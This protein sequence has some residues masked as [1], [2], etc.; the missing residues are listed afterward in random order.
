[1]PSNA[2]TTQ[3]RVVEEVCDA[4]GVARVP[5]GRIPRGLLTA[6]GAVSPLVREFREVRHQ[7]ERPWLVDDTAARTAFGLEP[8]P[9]AEIV[10]ELAA[11]YRPAR[12]AAP[13]T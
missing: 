10:A 12:A 11:T 7:Y 4:M 8:T 13:A 6:L 5:V 3:R 1:V 2:P 9:W